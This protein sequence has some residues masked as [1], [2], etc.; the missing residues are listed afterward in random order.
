[1]ARSFMLLCNSLSPSILT[2][3]SMIVI[4]STYT[5]TPPGP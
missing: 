3:I 5:I 1:M 2:L 4:L